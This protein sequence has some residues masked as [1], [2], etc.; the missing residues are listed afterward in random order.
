MLDYKVVSLVEDKLGEVQ[1]QR[2]RDAMIKYLI[3]EAD[4]EIAYYLVCTYITALN[5]QFMD[6]KAETKDLAVAKELA[7]IDGVQLVEE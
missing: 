6:G 2:E 3:Q 4:F 1:D 7:K 5:I